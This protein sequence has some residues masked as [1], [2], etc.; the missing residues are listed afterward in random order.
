MVKSLF[1]NPFSIIFSEKYPVVTAMYN[2]HET[3]NPKLEEA[4]RKQ[5]D[6][7]NYKSNVKAQMTEWRMF[8]ESGGEH[9]QEVIEFSMR[10]A[11]ENSPAKFTPGCSDCWGAI[12]RKGEYAQKH[13]HWPCLWSWT[14]YVNVS[15]KCSPLVFPNAGE[16]GGAF[17]RPKNGL[18]VLFPGWVVHEV[19]PQ[20]NDHERVMVAGN[21]IALEFNGN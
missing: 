3:L 2:N 13:D 12:Y 8:N 10:V 6:R 18:L 14:Y 16:D 20:Q 11:V 5:G 4:I 19:K 15:D 1:N 17:V 7:I 21:L 9:F